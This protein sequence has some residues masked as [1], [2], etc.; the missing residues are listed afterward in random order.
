MIEAKMKLKIGTFS[1]IVGAVFLLLLFSS[2]LLVTDYHSLV[3]QSLPQN[4][5]TTAET[6]AK[7][8]KTEIPEH[9]TLDSFLLKLGLH[10]LL[11]FILLAITLFF[12]RQ[13]ILLP[14]KTFKRSF[15]SLISKHPNAQ[16]NASNEFAIDSFEQ[17][18]TYL[19]ETTSDNIRRLNF[20][21][22]LGRQ[23]WFDMDPINNKILISEEYAN[24]LGYRADELS[25]NI[26]LWKTRIHPEDIEPVVIAFIKTLKYDLP[27]TQ[28]FRI[29]NK[30]D[31]YI[32]LS[33]V[34]QTVERNHLGQSTRIVA[35]QKDISQSKLIELRES[36]RVKVLE[37]LVNAAPL[38]EILNA[39]I[40]I[41]EHV[42]PGLICSI[43]TLEKDQKRVFTAASCRL[44]HFF[45]EAINGL[46]IGPNEGS[47]GSAMYSGQRV[48][49]EDIN[50]DPSWAKYKELALQAG[51]ASCWSE[52]II[53]SEGKVLGSFAIYH[54]MPCVPKESDFSQIEFVSKLAAVAI[55]RSNSVEQ[56]QLFSRVFSDTHEA[57]II[58]DP[59]G[60]IIE[61]NPAFCIITGYDREEVIGKNPNILSSGKHNQKFFREMWNSVIQHGHWQGE[62]WNN[63]KNGELYIE[64]LSISSLNDEQGNTLYYVGLFSDIT[65]TIK[66]QEE[67]KLMA[68]Y[69]MLTQLPNR[70]LFTDR[71]HQAIAHSKRTNKK[72]AVCFLDLDNFKPINDQYGHDIGDRLLIEVSRRLN[73][74]IRSEDTVSR[75]GGDEFTLLLGDIDNYDV[76]AQ[77]LQ[78]I[79]E[80]LA[81]PFLL[82]G[83]QLQV[84]ASCGVTLYPDDDADID[85]LLRHADHAMYQAKLIGKNRFKLFN[86]EKNLK[87]ITRHHRLA[88]IEQALLEGQLALYYQ[89]KI[90]MRT[91]EF[92]GVEALIRWIHPEK[93]LIP[94]LEFLPTIEGTPLE[95]QVGEWV[96]SSA[97]AQMKIWNSIDLDLEVSVNIS[98]HH[99]QSPNFIKFISNKLAENSDINPEKLQLEIL[100]SSVLGD[101]AVIS[102]TLRA[103]QE[104]LGVNIAL[105]D[106]GTG[107]SS[108]THMRNLPTNTIKIDQS[109]VRD[110]LDD[111]SDYVI[112]NGVIGLAESFERKVIAEGVE[113]TEHGL[114]L[115]MMGC[116][117]AQGYEIAKPMPANDIY[118]WSTN[119]V[120]NEKWLKWGREK[121]TELQ[122]KIALFE[123]TCSW[124]KNHFVTNILLEPTMI[125]DW[126]IMDN[127]QCHCGRWIE[128]AK[129]EKIFDHELIY[130]L[131]IFHKE[132]HAR[133]NELRMMYE[134]GNHD[135]AKRGLVK[136]ESTF[137]N[138]Q[139]LLTEYI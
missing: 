44:P 133:A 57:I 2:Y 49:A 97:I 108:L 104:T 46:E 45:S 93:G 48:I 76:C 112:V 40:N 132:I 73:E 34:G 37:L 47:C 67:L 79:L 106:F 24:L 102:D 77:S 18:L 134:A 1:L 68:H 139:A 113:S 61:V 51:L 66:Q 21:H 128:R 35:V 107:Y 126:P 12:I 129:R 89:P 23:G 30:N 15:H 131:D 42:D 55:E 80:S 100:E 43:L 117:L 62:V 71:F 52:P 130:Q 83:R 26:N 92:F 14:F 124:W 53:G 127:R 13:K 123:L 6:I 98:S 60:N 109:F 90:N 121:H 32:W 58:T 10:L 59:S 88:E 78:R 101:L 84:T 75:Q 105:D 122:S 54:N 110:V 22:R 25:S 94:P 86:T 115:L 125:R 65:N 19:V 64:L 85:T 72:L 41:L 28:E 36:V 9:Q 17:E 120:A 16:T 81:K 136:M 82:D 69:D 138:M 70:T 63:K 11:F 33:S 95:V 118:K 91:G 137:E 56:I 99:L 116:E 39:I 114:I 135:Q 27:V 3:I 29:K 87:R 50:T 74:Q 4:E 20:S 96:I 38:N 119:Q 111:P 8:S 31:E 103:C 7:S 5:A